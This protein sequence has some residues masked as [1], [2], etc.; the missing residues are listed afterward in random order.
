MNS[1]AFPTQNLSID[2]KS[3]MNC[4]VSYLKLVL[5]PTKSTMYYASV[6]E[7]FL[8]NISKQIYNQELHVRHFAINN[9]MHAPE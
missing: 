6:F 2:E 7:Y 1:R 4:V 3:H 9:K 5:T 8:E